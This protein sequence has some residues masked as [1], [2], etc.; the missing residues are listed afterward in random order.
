MIFQDLD[1]LVDIGIR[2]VVFCLDVIDRVGRLLKD[3]R[4]EVVV[5][6]IYFKVS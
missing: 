4:K 5:L 1:D 6:V 2:A 3:L